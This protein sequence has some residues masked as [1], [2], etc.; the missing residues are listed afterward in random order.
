MDD[1]GF[2]DLDIQGRGASPALD[3]LESNKAYFW[4]VAVSSE[5]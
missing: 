5:L 4:C 1:I 2:G 3:H